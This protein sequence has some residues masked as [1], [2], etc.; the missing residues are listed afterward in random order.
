MAEN[1][2]NMQLTAAAKLYRRGTLLKGLESAEITKLQ[3]RRYRQGEHHVNLYPGLAEAM[4]K[5]L[6]QLASANT[7]AIAKL[8]GR[9][10]C[11]N[12][13]GFVSDWE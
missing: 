8:F 5:L 1:K 10:A 3:A 9:E 13:A 12:S 7:E 6:W 4:L 2:I 11:G